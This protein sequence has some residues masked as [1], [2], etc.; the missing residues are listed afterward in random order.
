MYPIFFWFIIIVKYNTVSY[1]N[2]II[3]VLNHLTQ[4]FDKT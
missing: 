2:N 3:F 4:Q 1:K